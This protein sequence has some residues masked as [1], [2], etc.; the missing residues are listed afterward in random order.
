MGWFRKWLRG[1]YTRPRPRPGQQCQSV[2]GLL[3]G[4]RCELDDGHEGKHE[5]L[6]QWSTN[7]LTGERVSETK[8]LWG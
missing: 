1:D 2:S 4:Y 5:A 8:A 6:I 3:F 7:S